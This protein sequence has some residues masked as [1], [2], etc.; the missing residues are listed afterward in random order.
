MDIYLRTFA[1]SLHLTPEETR[2]IVAE[3]RGN[4]EDLTARL[5][6]QGYTPDEAEREAVRRFDEARGLARS[7]RWAHRGAPLLLQILALILGV[8]G[9]CGF[10]I[11]VSVLLTVAG[12]SIFSVQSGMYNPDFWLETV[13]GLTI[14]T[15]AIVSVVGA[16]AILLRWRAHPRRIG[17]GFVT[18]LLYDAIVAVPLLGVLPQPSP[19][20]VSVSKAARLAAYGL[21][22]RPGPTQ[23]VNPVVVDR[24]YA[25][26]TITYV[27]YH[28][29]N[30]ARDSELVPALTDDRGRRYDFNFIDCDPCN[31]S[32]TSRHIGGLRQI[33]PW[34]VSEQGLARFAALRS[35]SRAAVLHFSAWKDGPPIETVRVPLN[36]RGWGRATGGTHPFIVTQG[37]GIRVNLT[38]VV[39]GLTSST[40]DYTIDAT[41]AIV[42]PGG[43]MYNVK[44]D[45]T[46]AGVQPIGQISWSVA[47]DVFGDGCRVV[48]QG[49]AHCG[50]AWLLPPIPKGTRLTLTVRSVIIYPHNYG[51]PG[52]YTLSG[53]W[54]IQFVMP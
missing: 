23:P 29:P 14:L 24:V 36:L 39:R 49:G 43:A 15:G 45:F 53:P 44:A 51:G 19:P 31:G 1:Q 6:T 54:H 50:P 11:A 33:L 17:I 46:D 2:A 20:P 32:S 34:R 8:V 40:I 9:A 3:V 30:A 28:I 47:G 12:R 42:P 21:V 16:A 38:R 13:A 18:V 22:G 5:R 10:V 48:A 52:A 37:R 26:R 35:D 4:L 25:D 27:Q 41:R 7:M